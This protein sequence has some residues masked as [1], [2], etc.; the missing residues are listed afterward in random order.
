MIA[1]KTNT[2]I[3]NYAEHYILK[4]NQDNKQKRELVFKRKICN[5][6]FISEQKNFAYYWD[7]ILRNGTKP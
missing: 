4:L 1:K 6:F 3:R 7:I 5:L 2:P